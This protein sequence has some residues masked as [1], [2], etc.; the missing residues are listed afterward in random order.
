MMSLLMV[1]EVN[2]TS[3]LYLSSIFLLGARGGVDRRRVQRQT[4]RITL[5]MSRA[6]GYGAEPPVLLIALFYYFLLNF[7]R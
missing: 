4:N 1:D 6:N 5:L 2:A 7:C 3:F